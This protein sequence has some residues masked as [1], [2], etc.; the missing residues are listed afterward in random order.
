MTEE[1]PRRFLDRTTPPNIVTLIMLSAIPALSMTLFLPSLPNMTE[2]FDTEYRVMQLSVATYLFVN[3]VLQVIVGPI[4][5]YFGRRIVVQ[6]SIVLFLVATFGC[7]LSPTVEIFLVFRMCQAVIV[8]GMVLS[9]SIVRDMYELEKSASVM[10]YVTMGMAVAP[11]LGPMIGGTLDDAFGWKASFSLLLIIG[12]TLLVICYFD[13]GETYAGKPSSLRVQVRQYPELFGSRRFWGYCL[14][15]S[16]SSGAFFAYLGGSPFVGT[17]HYGLTASTLG[18]YFG[19]AAFG[20]MLGNFLSGRFSQSVGVNRMVLIGTVVTILGP[21]GTVIA[22]ASGVSHPIGFFGFATILGIGNG[23][24]VPNTMAGM[25]SVRP[26]LAGTASGIGGAIIIG[27]G[28][29][30][31]ALAGA[32]LT[33]ESGPFP[34][35][36]IMLACTVIGFLCA[37]YVLWVESRSTARSR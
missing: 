28:A 27:I 29:G 5:D 32:T 1:T 26:Q 19:M 23:L 10:G 9:R 14:I 11:M 34:L 20:Y 7:M 21:L 24:V 13:Q 15:S 12:M 37:I 6:W 35:F 25:L 22:V 36:L 4:S 17:N 8:S 30:L 16:F 33:D 3:A 31:S 2:Y 18:F